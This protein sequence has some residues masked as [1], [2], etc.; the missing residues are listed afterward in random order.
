M[1][2][3]KYWC[4]TSLTNPTTFDESISSI[5]DLQL[6]KYDVIFCRLCPY[7]VLSKAVNAFRAIIVLR[8]FTLTESVMTSV[9]NSKMDGISSWAKT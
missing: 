2:C 4:R 1:L 9:I 8:V 6:Y 5:T 7:M 3:E